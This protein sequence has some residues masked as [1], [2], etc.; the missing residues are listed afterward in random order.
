MNL[1]TIN[2]TSHKKIT[3][4]EPALPVRRWSHLQLTRVSLCDS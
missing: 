3:I 1:K 2:T 4:P